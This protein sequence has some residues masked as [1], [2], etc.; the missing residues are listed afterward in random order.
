[1][2][3][4]FIMVLEFSSTSLQYLRS[5]AKLQERDRAGDLAQW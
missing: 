4:T 1:M 3:K 5:T 2:Y